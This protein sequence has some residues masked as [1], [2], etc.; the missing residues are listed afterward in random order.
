MW[1]FAF[2]RRAQV[3][4]LGLGLGLAITL[5]LSLTLTLTLTLT[6]GGGLLDDDVLIEAQPRLEIG[7]GAI[8]PREIDLEPARVREV[9]LGAGEL[10]RV[11]LVH[12]VRG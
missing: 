2:D 8:S 7:R 12:L 5:T 1:T 11:R 6:L 9:A 4:W 10:D 3:T